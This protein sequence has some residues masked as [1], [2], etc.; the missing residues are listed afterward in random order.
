[1]KVGNVLHPVGASARIPAPWKE[2]WHE[3]KRYRA[4]ARSNA[5][6]CMCG[7]C[8]T[9]RSRAFSACSTPRRPAARGHHERTRGSV[10]WT[11]MR[12]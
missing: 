12:A 3:R 8:A 5:N 11:R 10:R 6:G 1:M 2:S 9:A 4:V 7:G